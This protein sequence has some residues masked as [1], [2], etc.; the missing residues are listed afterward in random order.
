MHS[1]TAPTR[2]TFLAGSGLAALAAL[3]P[4]AVQKPESDNPD[5]YTRE[6]W[7]PHVGTV[8]GVGQ[9]TAKLAE[10]EEDRHGAFLIRFT[11]VTG[12]AR[13]DLLEV[14]H[15]GLGVV[16]LMVSWGKGSATAVVNA[17]EGNK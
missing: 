5:P 6:A 12:V 10:V 16:P 14:A 15:P 13:D 11:K 9:G 8:L 17:T 2:R 1:L 4:V 3:A 7:E